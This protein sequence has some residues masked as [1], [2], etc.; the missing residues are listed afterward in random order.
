MYIVAMFDCNNQRLLAISLSDDTR[1]AVRDR[2]IDGGSPL[3][4]IEF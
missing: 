3:E 2:M 4:Y 1:K